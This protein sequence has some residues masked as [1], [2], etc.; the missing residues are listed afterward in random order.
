MSICLRRREFIA[1]LGDAAAWPLAVR[2]Q[3]QA[4]PVRRVGVLMSIASDDP[5]AQLHVAA[6]EAGLRDLGWVQGR[7]LH[8]E[9]RRA[10][11]QTD[12]LRPQ[13]AE[14]VASVPDLILATST[15]ATIV[16]REQTRTLPI[17]FV[18]VNDPVG[19]GYPGGN[20]TGFT[21]FEFAIGTKWLQMLK[22]VSP[23]V[24]RVAVIFNPATAPYAGL[25]WQPIEAAAPFFSVEP[26]QSPT[27]DAGA[28]KENDRSVCTRAEWWTTGTATY[29]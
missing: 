3:Q 29:H 21:A 14:L 6:F 24:K 9:Y 2:A 25:F 28:I 20:L 5:E 15:P 19:Q 7:N 22:E 23:A 8:I 4:T 12:V 13:A 27:R 18:F 17:V 26:I 10:S 1:A 16:L 11:G